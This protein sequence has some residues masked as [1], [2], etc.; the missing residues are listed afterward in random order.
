MDKKTFHPERCYDGI[1]EFDD[2]DTRLATTILV[3][4][5]GAFL[6]GTSWLLWRLTHKPITIKR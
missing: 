3:V 5:A 6:V 1:N 4:G 2:N